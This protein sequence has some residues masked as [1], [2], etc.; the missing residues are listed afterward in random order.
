MIVREGILFKEIKSFFHLSMGFAFLTALS[1]QDVEGWFK[2][3]IKIVTALD[4]FLPSQGRHCSCLSI[5]RRDSARLESYGC[6]L[7]QR[8]SAHLLSFPRCSAPCKSESWALSS[9]ILHSWDRQRTGGENLVISKTVSPRTCCT[10]LLITIRRNSKNKNPWVY[11][12]CHLIK[13]K[14]GTNIF[15]T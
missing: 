11:Y 1:P 15:N 9:H 3:Y 12:E 5:T 6:S 10:T 4:F 13:P 8:E 14:V 2:F 7:S